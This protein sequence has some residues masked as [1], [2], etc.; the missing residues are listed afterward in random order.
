M[1]KISKT[2]ISWG[3]ASILFAAGAIAAGQNGFAACDCASDVEPDLS[4]PMSHPVNRCAFNQTKEVSWYSWFSGKS[5]SGQF[6][7]LDLLELLTR[8]SHSNTSTKQSSS[9]SSF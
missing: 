6:H 1:K 4:L 2:L 8:N 7:Y 3:I 9:E 5:Q